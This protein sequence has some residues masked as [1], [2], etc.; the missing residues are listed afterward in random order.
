MPSLL[1]R[2]VSEDMK[3]A[4]ALRAAQNDRSQQAEARAILEDA[5]CPGAGS[6][7]SLLREAADSAGGIDFAC[8]QRHAPRV[9]GI[10]S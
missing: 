6:W 2:D 10:V 4:L 9:T 5:L 3:H 8:P 1:V 7:V